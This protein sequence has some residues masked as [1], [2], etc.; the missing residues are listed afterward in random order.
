[1]L[2]VL[3]EL[4][5]LMSFSSFLF[6]VCDPRGAEVKHLNLYR[7]ILN[8][9]FTTGV[10]AHSCRTAGLPLRRFLPVDV[11]RFIYLLLGM[12]VGVSWSSDLRCQIYRMRACC[13]HAG[14]AHRVFSVSLRPGSPWP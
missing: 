4:F 9:S 3:I 2:G 11:P 1:M 12:V 10:V 5:C 8:D 7:Y 14:R 13:T 6:V